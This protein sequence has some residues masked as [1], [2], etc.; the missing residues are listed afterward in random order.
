MELVEVTN[1]LRRNVAESVPQHYG[2]EPRNK[3]NR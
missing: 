3:P 1:P 2:V